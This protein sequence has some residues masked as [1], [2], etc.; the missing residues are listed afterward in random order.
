VQASVDVTLSVY[1]KV[2]Q[3]TVVQGRRNRV[4]CISK[5]LQGVWLSGVFVTSH[6]LEFLSSVFFFKKANI[7]RHLACFRSSSIKL[8]DETVHTTCPSLKYAR[9]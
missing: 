6:I 8:E 1:G 7:F 5:N 9:P 4:G 2:S 3:L